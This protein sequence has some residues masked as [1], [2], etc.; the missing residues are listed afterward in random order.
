M[1]KYISSFKKRHSGKLLWFVGQ[2]PNEVIATTR[3]KELYQKNHYSLYG[4]PMKIV[5]KDLVLS[6]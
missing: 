6:N 2:Y 5:E 1:E 4:G 3:M